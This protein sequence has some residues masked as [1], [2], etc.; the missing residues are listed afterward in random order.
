M[1]QELFNRINEVFSYDIEKVVLSN[2]KIEEYKKYVITRKVNG[3]QVEKFT[4]KQ[5]FHENIDEQILRDYCI[6]AM[7][8][9]FKQFNA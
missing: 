2:G 5:A 9:G 6:S 7:E 4:D 3:F 1:N 8:S